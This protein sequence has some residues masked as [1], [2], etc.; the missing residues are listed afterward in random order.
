MIASIVGSSRHRLWID[1]CVF[2]TIG[3]KFGNPSLSVGIIPF[4]HALT[5]REY[6]LAGDY[7]TFWRI[8]STI[9]AERSRNFGLRLSAL[10]DWERECAALS[11][12]C[13]LIPMLDPVLPKM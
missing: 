3:H 2:C 9:G 11:V 4:I 7:A 10:P 5:A 6:R 1:G 8:F 12:F 13:R